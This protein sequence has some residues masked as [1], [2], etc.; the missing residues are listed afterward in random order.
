MFAIDKKQVVIDEDRLLSLIAGFSWNINI[1]GRSK[2][3]RSQDGKSGYVYSN[4]TI[5]P[6]YHA[7]TGYKADGIAY[8]RVIK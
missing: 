5:S 7:C 2:K 6:W 3:A 4:H 1:C 8:N